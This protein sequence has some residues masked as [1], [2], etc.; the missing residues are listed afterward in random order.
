MT[1][2][3]VVSFGTKQATNANCT[4]SALF[5]A[6]Q[7]LATFRAVVWLGCCWTWP[8]TWD[9]RCLRTRKIFVYEATEITEHDGISIIQY[10]VVIQEWEME[11][12]PVATGKI[13]KV[14]VMI[15]VRFRVTIC[16]YFIPNNRARSLSTLMAV[17]VNKD[18]PHNA[19]L[20]MK[21]APLAYRQRL[22][23]SLTKE[24]Q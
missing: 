5:T 3:S 2:S 6:L 24:I 15:N 13:Q 8:C 10:Q 4:H 16:L 18:T 23:C 14:A 22:Q 1:S 20:D 17:N 9:W 21:T 7:Y 12:D 11:N 19:I